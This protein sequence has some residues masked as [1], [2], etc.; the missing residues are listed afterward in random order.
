MTP[1]ETTIRQAQKIRWLVDFA[2]ESSHPVPAMRRGNGSLYLDAHKWKELANDL[3]ALVARLAAAE[4]D[5]RE[6]IRT[7]RIRERFSLAAEARV[8]EL[9]QERD[10]AVAAMREIQRKYVRTDKA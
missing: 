1:E 8:K 5:R 6:L 7:S 4:R 10:Q 9:E 3:D 2:R